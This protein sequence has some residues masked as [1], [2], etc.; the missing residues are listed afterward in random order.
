MV[1]GAIVTYSN[2]F[3]ETRNNI[4][5]LLDNR[6][7]VAD[8]ISVQYRKWIYSREPDVK[9][10]DFKGYP[11]IILHDVAVGF[12]ERKTVNVKSGY[13]HMTCEIEIVT[14]DVGVGNMAGRGAT[15]ND[16]IA[17]DVLETFLN[18][19]NLTTLRTNGLAF[20]KPEATPATDEE[21]YSTKVF[22]RS[23]ILT[24]GA[25]KRLSA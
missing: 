19:A 10:A 5:A 23:I 17:N 11:Y 16:S 3:S 22:R 18:A 20:I 6:S 1:T 21:S 4:L 25:R 15:D 9:A 12:D 7:N 13:V 24:M 14:S 2:L 8:P